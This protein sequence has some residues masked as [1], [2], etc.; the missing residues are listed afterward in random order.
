MAFDDFDVVDACAL[1]DR[2][3]GF[4]S[5]NTATRGHTDIFTI[6]AFDLHLRPESNYDWYDDE[7]DNG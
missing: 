3:G 4:A 7:K 1:H 6:G 5:R 2:L